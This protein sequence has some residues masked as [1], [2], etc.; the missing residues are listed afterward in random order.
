MRVALLCL[1]GALAC[2]GGVASAQSTEEE[3]IKSVLQAET[4]AS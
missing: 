1:I 4:K 3:A 2:G